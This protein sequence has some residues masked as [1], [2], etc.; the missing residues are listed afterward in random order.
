M[1]MVL[2]PTNP[3]LDKQA[4]PA[5]ATEALLEK[6]RELFTAFKE[7]KAAYCPTNSDELFLIE[8]LANKISQ[9][10]RELLNE[11]GEKSNPLPPSAR[12]N[13]DELLPFVLDLIAQTQPG[14]TSKGGLLVRLP[15]GKTKD[16]FPKSKIEYN[17]LEYPKR[18]DDGQLGKYG[19]VEVQIPRWLARKRD[20][21]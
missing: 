11:I 17:I 8:S 7:W 19:R 9:Q 21:I 18:S 3:L 4:E 2:M 20:M 13:N 1:D 16:W 12:T 10:A 15:D 6:G 14:E 5:T